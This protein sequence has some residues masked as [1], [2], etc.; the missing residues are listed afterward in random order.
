MADRRMAFYAPLKAPDHPTPSGDRRMA[1]LL[2]QA[3]E[4]AGAAVT[5]RKPPERTVCA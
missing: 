4:A 1:R 5:H 3:L 2:I